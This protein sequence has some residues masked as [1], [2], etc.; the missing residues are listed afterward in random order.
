MVLKTEVR[1]TKDDRE[2]S[3]FGSVVRYTYYKSAVRSYQAFRPFVRPGR[4]WRSS[5]RYPKEVGWLELRFLT[6]SIESCSSFAFLATWITNW[7]WADTGQEIK[8][9]GPEWAEN[10]TS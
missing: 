3:W 6:Y 7:Y 10:Q 5:N 1:L 2:E 9:V 8:A 4:R